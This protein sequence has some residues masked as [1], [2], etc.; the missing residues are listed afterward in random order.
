MPQISQRPSHDIE[1]RAPA[2]AQSKK[3]VRGLHSCAH[4]VLKTVHCYTDGRA[5]AG[6]FHAVTDAAPSSGRRGVHVRGRGLR[7]HSPTP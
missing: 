5:R 7:S 6:T 3:M 2:E 1:N 4:G